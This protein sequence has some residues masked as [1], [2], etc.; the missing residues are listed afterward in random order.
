VP[1]PAR[2]G[3]DLDRAA[4]YQV[5][6]V[7]YRDMDW[8]MLGFEPGVTPFLDEPPVIPISHRIAGLPAAT[9]SSGAKI[10]SGRDYDPCGAEMADMESFAVLRAARSFGVPMIGLRGISDGRSELTGCTTGPSTCT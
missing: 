4:V 6:S 10:I 3:R 9:L 2:N 1:D 8:S 7:K 5:A